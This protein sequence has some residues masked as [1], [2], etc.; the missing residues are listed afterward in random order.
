[1]SIEWWMAQPEYQ[2]W[3][4]AR[5]VEVTQYAPPIGTDWVILTER[6]KDS[7]REHPDCEEVGPPFS[8]RVSWTESDQDKIDRMRRGERLPIPE[9]FTHLFPKEV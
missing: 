5:I 4:R 7:Y 2:R 1:M 3:L 8:L 6:E 9:R